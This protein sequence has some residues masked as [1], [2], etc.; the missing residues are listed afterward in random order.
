M[1][2]LRAV[3][4]EVLGL[5]VDDGRLALLTALLIGGVSLLVKV[6]ALPGLWGGALLLIGCLAILASSL[7]QARPRR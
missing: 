1:K 5:F 6:L 7:A 2:V 3:L 4:G